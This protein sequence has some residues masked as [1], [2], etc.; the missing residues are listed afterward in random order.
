MILDA[1]EAI[2]G[3]IRPTGKSRPSRSCT[4]SNR[5]LEKS[6]RYVKEDSEK[7]F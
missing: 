3:A 6:Y 7:E 5:N 1:I 2:T 4:A